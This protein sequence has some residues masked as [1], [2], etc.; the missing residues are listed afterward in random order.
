MVDWQ[1]VKRAL[2]A[3]AAASDNRIPG[4]PENVFTDVY[5]RSAV[6]GR[7]VITTTD[8]EGA[9]IRRIPFVLSFNRRICSI[10]FA[11]SLSSLH[12]LPQLAVAALRFG[13]TCRWHSVDQS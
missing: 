3:I 1:P 5:L 9:W 12:L 10:D 13:R 6:T 8:D 7:F 11:E 4:R 2:E